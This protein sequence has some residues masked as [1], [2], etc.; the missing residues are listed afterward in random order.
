MN[1]RHSLTLDAELSSLAVIR[2]FVEQAATELGVAAPVI[3]GLRRAVDEAAANIILHGYRGQV[4]RFEIELRRE[5]GDLLIC[6]RD[7]APPFDPTGVCPP[8]ISQPLAERPVGGMGL[9]FIRQATDELRHCLRPTGGN[10]LTLIKKGII[11]S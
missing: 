4:G 1:P 2:R 8:D 3:P 11:K 7:Q 6:L 10:E 9:Q 5:A